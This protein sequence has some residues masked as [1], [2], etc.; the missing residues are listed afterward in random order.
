MFGEN[1]ICQSKAVS[2]NPVNPDKPVKICFVAPKAY[3]LFNPAVVSV[4]GGAELQIALLARELAKDPCFEVSLLVADYG[5]PDCENREG[6]TIRKSVVLTRN[7]LSGAVRIWR[8]LKKADADLYMMSS[9][10]PGTPLVAAFCR[11]HEKKF[12]YR[13][14]SEVEC[15]GAM[16]RK[17]PLTGVFYRRALRQAHLV[18]TQNEYNRRQLRETV[19]VDALVVKNWHALPEADPAEKESVLWVGRSDRLKQPELFLELAREIPDQE[20]VMIC[21][22][23]TGDADYKTLTA[24]AAA[25]DNLTFYPHVAYHDV[26]R[27]FRQAKVLV[28]T[29][30]AEGFPNVFIQACK[31]ATPILS[32]AV[33]PDHFIDEYNCGLHCGNDR[34][35]LAPALTSLLQNDRYLDLGR[36]ARRY[37][38]ENHDIKRLIPDLKRRFIEIVV[39]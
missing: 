17:A 4:F 21:Q 24:A 28:N 20:F 14:A 35:K 9:A 19:G 23:A 15:N 7:P 22:R 34:D 30:T 3:P 29:S 27:Y 1:G 11:R 8:R 25:I 36:N 18:I 16:F 31:A 33:N 13:T 39:G 37:V 10:S 38:E 5:Q 32:L 12:I 6:I 2:M 26:D